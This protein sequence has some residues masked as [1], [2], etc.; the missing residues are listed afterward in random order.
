MLF[1]WT[2]YSSNPEKKASHNYFN[3]SGNKK[4]FLWTKSALMIS[5]GSHGIED[6]WKF[7]F[8]VTGINDILKLKN[9]VIY[10]L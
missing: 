10:K 2:F 9:K 5:E 3:I 8:A 6:C 1:F 4:C 7:S